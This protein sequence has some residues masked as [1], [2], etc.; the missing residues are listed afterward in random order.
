MS[1]TLKT[2]AISVAFGT[3]SFFMADENRTVRV[4]VGQELLTR[5]EGPPPKS[6]RDF[7]E[8]LSR[9]KTEFVRI[10][11]HKYEVGLYHSEVNVRVVR[12]TE[13]DLG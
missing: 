10:A 9:R 5:I 11:T 4:D 1:L 2:S 3:A 6:K 13:E 8:R 7:A 12:I